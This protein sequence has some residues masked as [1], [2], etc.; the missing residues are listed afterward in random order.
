TAYEVETVI[1]FRTVLFRSSRCALGR[2]SKADTTRCRLTVVVG[3]A[4]TLDSYWSLSVR[5]FV[6]EDEVVCCVLTRTCGEQNYSN[7]SHDHDELTI[8]AVD[9]DSVTKVATPDASANHLEGDERGSD[10]GDEADE[11]QDSAN[12][13]NSGRDWRSNACSR[14]AHSREC[15]S[16]ARDS[17]FVEFLPAV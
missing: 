15:F 4:R 11:N 2:T 8:I 7:G 6:L 1:E 13:F 10:A 17:P 3:L 14:N 9:E 12:Q 16:G 5:L